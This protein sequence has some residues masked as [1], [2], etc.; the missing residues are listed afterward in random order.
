MSARKLYTTL[1]FLEQEQREYNKTKLRLRPNSMILLCS[2]E[3]RILLKPVLRLLKNL[4]QKDK[5]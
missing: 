1:T 5:E 4:S 2:L 3:H